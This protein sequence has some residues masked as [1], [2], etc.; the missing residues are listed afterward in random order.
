MVALS[1]RRS[2]LLWRRT[3]SG[4][5]A[6]VACSSI[7]LEHMRALDERFRERRAELDPQE[8]RLDECERVGQ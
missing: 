7:V 6:H 4:A 2:Q 3:T 5:T 1:A 8:A